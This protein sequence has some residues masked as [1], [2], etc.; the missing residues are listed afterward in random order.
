MQVIGLLLGA[1]A[2]SAQPVRSRTAVGV[3]LGANVFAKRTALEPS[4]V[5]G[6][7]AS[8]QAPWSPARRRAD[9]PSVSIG[10]LLDVSRPKTNGEQFPLAAVDRGDTTYLYAMAQR[11]TLVESSVRAQVGVPLAGARVSAYAGGGLYAL[12]PG[13]RKNG[14]SRLVHPMG[15]FG[16][17]VDDPLTKT[18]AVRLQIGGTSYLRFDRNALDATRSLPEAQRIRDAAPAPLA[19]ARA[20]TNLQ[21]SIVFRFTPGGA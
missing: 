8:W 10:V 13:S 18:L 16:I 6:L 2:L 5:L 17:A 12:L 14:S 15:S 20:P 9:A 19:A 1:S 11:V 21:Y 3:R 4:P 7:E